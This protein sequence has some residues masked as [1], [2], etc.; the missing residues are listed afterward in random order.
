M[1][2]LLK[3][4]LGHLVVGR[5]IR[6]L[7]QINQY[8]HL[9]SEIFC[10]LMDAVLQ[11]RTPQVRIDGKHVRILQLELSDTPSKLFSTTFICWYSPTNRG[12]FT[13]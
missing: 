13:L 11:I 6:F 1:K 9:L 7:H 5:H 12:Y 4:F 10:S 8:S 3:L 2:T